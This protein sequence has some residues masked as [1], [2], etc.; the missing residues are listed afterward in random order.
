MKSTSWIIWLSYILRSFGRKVS[1]SAELY[2]STG[3]ELSS[4]QE[5]KEDERVTLK[6]GHY[7]RI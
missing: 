6:V 2:G 1:A 5:I 7:L 3:A 4:L